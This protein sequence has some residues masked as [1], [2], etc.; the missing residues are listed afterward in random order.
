MMSIELNC[1]VKDKEAI[2]T[3]IGL[4]QR[5]S[6]LSL[7]D[8]N[9]L[10]GLT[11][12]ALLPHVILA[13]QLDMVTDEPVYINAG[14]IY[15]PLLK[16]LKFGANEWNVNYEHP[17]L[18]KLFIGLTLYLNTFLA[19]PLAELLAARIPSIIMGTLLVVAIYWLG[20]APVGRVVALVAALCLAFSPWLAFFSAIAYLD[21]PMTAL[22]TIAYLLL[23]HA[24]QRPTLY[25]LSAVMVGLA[26]AS[27]YPAVLAVPSMILFTVYYFFLLRPRLPVEQRSSMPWG[28]WIGSI[29]L[30]PLTFLAA[31]PAIW[32]S[33]YG[34]LIHSFTFEWNHAAQGHPT[35]MAGQFSTHAPH[36]AILY[37]LF[38]KIS[39]FVTVSAAFYA[40][41]ALVQLIRFHLHIPNI[42]ISDVTLLSFILLWLIGIIGMF[43]LLT[44]VVGTHYELPAAPPVALAGVYGLAIL[45]R[46]RRGQLFSSP[47]SES[48]SQEAIQAQTIHSLSKSKLNSAG[49]ARVVVLT[50]AL[51]VPHFI[52]LVSIPDAEGYS[53]ELFHGENAALQVAYPGYRD[54]LQWLSEHTRGTASIGLVTLSV[55]TMNPQETSWYSYNKDF[56]ARYHLVAVY[57]NT[58]FPAYDYLIFPMDLIQRGMTIPAPWKYHII[59]TV[60]GGNTTYCYI[61]AYASSTAIT[62]RK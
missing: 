10:I 51:T 22:I 23:W 41:Y 16:H 19:H 59:H 48:A 35:F 54:A 26:A 44:I 2:A 9:I 45:L 31:D 56:I 52:G 4:T 42:Q 61:T 20:R 18:V 6:R 50:T 14:K 53:S 43:S 24:L 36:W 62:G 38:T 21:I 57:P 12:A 15:F 46:Y 49:V 40:C 8:L 32:P 3:P 39:I 5:K 29:I 60:S 13:L 17:P 55:A 28:W 27:K 30:A 33:P 11:F 1:T 34:L 58:K 47:T 37:I 7:I 25:L